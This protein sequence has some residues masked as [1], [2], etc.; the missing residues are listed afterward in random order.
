MKNIYLLLLA[1]L[2]C[3]LSAQ[4]TYNADHSCKHRRHA[5][6]A[7]GNDSFATAADNSRSDT[8]DILNYTIRLDFPEFTGPVPITGSTDITF[9]PRMNNVSKMRLDLLKLTVDSIE[10]NGANL[11]F[12]YN[13]TVIAIDFQPS[14]LN[15]GDTTT[16]TVHYR[17]IPQGDASGWGGFYFNGGYAFNLGV[18]FAADPHAYG[19]VWFPC[20]D[21]F[22]ERSTYRFDI[23]SPAAKPAVCNGEL[24]NDTTYTNGRRLRTW[25]LN[26]TIPTYLASVAVAPY[27]LVNQTYNGINGPVPIVLA[28]AAADTNNL[29]S[30]FIHLKDALAAYENAYGPYLWNRVGYVLVPFNSG[31]MEHATNIAYPR[32]AANGT[33]SYETLMAHELAHHWWGDL[34]TCETQEDMWLNEGMASYSE[35]LFTE[36]VYGKAAYMA[37]VR[38]NHENLIHNAHINEDGYRAISGVPHEYTYGDH[39]YLKG[40]DVAHTMRGYLGDSL[41]FV[42]LRAQMEA[43]RFT[44][45]NSTEFMNILTAATGVDMTDFFNGWVFNGG[46]PHFSMNN[47]TVTPVAGGNYEV[48]VNVKQKLTGAPS[49]FNNV[50]LEITYFDAQWNRR[51]E[52]IIVSG[53][54]ETATHTIPFSPV[55]VAVNLDEKISHSAANDQKVIKA[56]GVNTFTNARMTVTVQAVADSAYILVEHNFA[57]PDPVKSPK[58]YRL[59]DYRYWKVSGIFPAGFDATAKVNYDGRTATT[60]YASW[61]DHTLINTK[62]DSLVLLYRENP[63]DD[64][65]L[66]P[67]FTKTM[68]NVNDKVGSITIDSLIAGEYVLA[69]RDYT[70]SSREIAE[71]A[72]ALLVY[73]NPSADVITV[74]AGD[75]TSETEISMTDMSGRRVMTF[76]SAQSITRIDV[77]SLPAG[78]YFIE[79]ASKGSVRRTRVAIA[80]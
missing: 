45:T 6:N 57:K 14:V 30:S 25:V 42:G 46:W 24:V 18:G 33:L 17:G 3:S 23:T 55:L 76:A 10:L 68:G 71:A 16:I 70:L 78:I 43:N 73:P 59:S 47:Y 51:T 52:K 37:D 13:D 54:D 19:R 66:F 39:V 21:N 49:Y 77:S 44:H 63:S 69:M 72:N 75:L 48:T 65:N 22:V 60:G 11:A 29:K 32:Y 15:I 5:A 2:P 41:F 1:I 50:P 61:L 80:R 20:F 27:T 40:A 79:A 36:Q 74:D 67:Y 58:P 26:E 53:A 38:S 64:W 34:A 4:L 62:E 8:I 12:T 28:A 56:A 7:R 35:F 31:A 9:A